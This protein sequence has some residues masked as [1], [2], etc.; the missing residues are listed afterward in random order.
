MGHLPIVNQETIEDVLNSGYI[1][2]KSKLPEKNLIGT[3]SS[4]FADVLAVRKGDL[5]FP[6]IIAS[7]KSPNVG[8]KYVFKVA[9]PPIFVRGQDDPIKI[10]LQK[11]G[12]EFEIPLPEAEAL[13]LWRK[14]LLWNAIGKKSLKRGKSFSHQLSMEDEL[15]LELLK[16]KNNNRTK[17][18]ILGIKSYHNNEPIHI[19]TMQRKW[20]SELKERV[21]SAP[22]EE[23]LSKLKLSGLPWVKGEYF[24]TEK[25]LEA[26]LMENIDKDICKKLL[27]LI[28][29]NSKL[30][31]FG[32]YLPF[33]V[34]GSNIDIV[35][36]QSKERK[37]FVTVVE[38]K[39]GSLNS[40]GFKHA[41]EQSI[42]YSLFLKKAFEAFGMKIELNPVVISGA[43][44]RR[45]ELTETRMTQN[46]L[47][48]SWISYRIKE[49]GKTEFNKIF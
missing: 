14:K 21:K 12:S 46:E 33:G 43:P 19:D 31:W 26:W 47:S 48:P 44:R 23:K 29:P 10:P 4:M 25:T 8:F 49:D 7:E 2:I 27:D 42:N 28:L 6:W 3:I 17:K 30:E 1:S 45:I 15:M 39:V 37:R 41:A 13:D 35:L 32:S 11:T 36:L 24:I 34:Q 38:L 18:V 22:R 40:E 9:G 20:D 16:G 5:V